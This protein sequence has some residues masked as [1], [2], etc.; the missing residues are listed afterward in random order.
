VDTQDAAALRTTHY[1]AT[2][3]E[4]KV[5]HE[6]LRI[7]RIR[8]DAAIPTFEAGQWLQIGL[9]AWEVGAPKLAV[10][11]AGG[12]ELA[13]AHRAAPPAA[14]LLRRTFSIG[15][16]ILAPGGERLLREG[17]EDAYEFYIALAG[18]G[19]AS[20]FAGRLFAR[21]PGE[22][23]WTAP[24]PK[25]QYTLHGVEPHHDVLFAATGTGEAPHNRMIWALLVRGH[26]GRIAA[27]VTTRTRADQGYRAVHERLQQL[28]PNYRY[29]AIA[30]REP[31][32]RGV[33]LQELLRSGQLESLAGFALDPQRTHVFLCGNPAMVGAPR[34]EPDG[35]LGFAQPG[36]M[37]ELLTQE[38]GFNAGTPNGTIHFERY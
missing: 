27:V 6:R 17:E 15:S 28:V 22:R 26:R 35:A 10:R 33:R 32:E 24:A 34:S 38:R 18:E 37:V 29:A 7:V 13:G 16:P 19:R 5:L 1:N 31:G 30:T 21:A 9:G 2:L 4:V 8:P 20:A 12:P 14:E 3:A 23:L 36:G 11:E 25:G